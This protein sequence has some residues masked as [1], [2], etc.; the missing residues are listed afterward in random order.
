MHSDKHI[1]DVSGT[2]PKVWPSQ[3]SP[4][5][6]RNSLLQSVGKFIGRAHPLDP[7]EKSKP[8]LALTGL[9]GQYTPECQ[10]VDG[11]GTSDMLR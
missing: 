8:W 7:Q 6:W 11:G 1:P 4:E 5:L 9:V 10:N 2:R 3:L